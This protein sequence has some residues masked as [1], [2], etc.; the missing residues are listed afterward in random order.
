MAS[1]LSVFQWSLVF[2]GLSLFSHR[3]LLSNESSHSWASCNDLRLVRLLTWQPGHQ[4]DKIIGIGLKGD[5]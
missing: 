3:I 4:E 2:L 5:A 1:L